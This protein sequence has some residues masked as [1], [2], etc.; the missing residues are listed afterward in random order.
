[1]GSHQ[2]VLR[3]F[4]VLGRVQALR[5]ALTDSGV[6]FEDL[7]LPI[8]EWAA[9]REDPTFGG[10]YRALPTLSWGEA[11]VAETLPIA[12][13][14][15]RRL[16][17]Y[18]GFD[19]AEIARREAVSSSCYVDVVT[20]LAE[21]I[22]ADQTYPGADVG[23][24]LANVLARALPKLE[25]IDAQIPVEGWL[26]GAR[27]VVPDFFAGETLEVLRHVVGPER[28]ARLAER[29]PRLWA[30]A[31]RLAERPGLAEARAK[32]PTAFTARA[33]EAAVLARLRA[34]DLAA[35]GL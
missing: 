29:Y 19:D 27:P 6:P 32:R 13:F 30:L 4:P 20:R 23:L 14:V 16:G 24:S 2:V 1:M 18:D 33:D 10:P 31:R 8:S 12:S 17:E 25:R 35:V 28:D 9:H 3:Y 22:R 7:R 26:G 34:V 5:H 11:T 15:S 21:V